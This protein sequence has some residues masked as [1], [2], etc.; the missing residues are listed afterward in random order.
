MLRQSGVRREVSWC[1]SRW[2]THVNLGG[3]HKLFRVVTKGRQRSMRNSL[4]VRVD[5]KKT[6]IPVLLDLMVDYAVS[7]CIMAGG[8]GDASQER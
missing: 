2:E 4:E 6:N 8:D 1:V 3:K 7:R 5:A